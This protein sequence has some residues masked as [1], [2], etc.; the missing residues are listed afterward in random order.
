MNGLASVYRY[1]QDPPRILVFP[2]LLSS[3]IVPGMLYWLP[4]S[5]PSSVSYVMMAFALESIFCQLRFFLH[6]CYAPSPNDGVMS[7][8]TPVSQSTTIFFYVQLQLGYTTILRK[9]K[10]IPL[11]LFSSGP[12]IISPVLYQD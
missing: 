7:M 4:S 6:H 10:I 11:K 3:Q 1:C 9:N 12:N 2:P 5:S 8:P